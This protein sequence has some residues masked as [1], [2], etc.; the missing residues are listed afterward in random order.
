MLSLWINKSIRNLK[1]ATEKTVMWSLRNLILANRASTFSWDNTLARRS[2][3]RADFR[4]NIFTE[5]ESV[6]EK[7]RE[8]GWTMWGSWC[9]WILPPRPFRVM[10]LSI[11]NSGWFTF[12]ITHF[13]SDLDSYYSLLTH[14]SRSWIIYNLDTLLDTIHCCFRRMV[15]S[16]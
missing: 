12:T 13:C 1:R 3:I 9:G 7:C 16:I 14:S 6:K 10:R 11:R 4:I 2:M 5:A 8:K 15:I